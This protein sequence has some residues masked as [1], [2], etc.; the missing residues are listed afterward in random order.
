VILH[1][2]LGQLVNAL[3][4]TNNRLLSNVI[5]DVVSLTEKRMLSLQSSCESNKVST[6][7]PS[8]FAA[9][10]NLYTEGKNSILKN[11]PKPTVKML[12]N[13]AYVPCVIAFLICLH[14]D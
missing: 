7:I 6:F 5:R 9:F 3:S 12:N 14:M 10:R 1:L 2:K 13:H 4:P 8:S 11:L